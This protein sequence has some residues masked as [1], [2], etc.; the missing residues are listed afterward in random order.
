MPLLPFNG[1]CAASFPQRAMSAGFSKIS[2]CSMGSV[3]HGFTFI[4]GLCPGISGVCVPSGGCLGVMG[5]T[6]HGFTSMGC[7]CPGISGSAVL[8]GGFLGGVCEGGGKGFTV[9]GGF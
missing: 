3:V 9:I 1:A 7:F 4:G 5:S 8:S 2:L 6:V